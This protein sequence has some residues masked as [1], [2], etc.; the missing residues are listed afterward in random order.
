M[1]TGQEKSQ[2][3]N[4]SKSLKPV[5]PGWGKL[6]D[7][8]HLRYFSQ[9]GFVILMAVIFYVR[10]LYG[11]GPQASA[12]EAFCPLGGFETL[13]YSLVNGGKF[14]EHS[15]LSNMVLFIA[16]LLTAVAAGGFF[17]GWVC[18]LGTIQQAVTGSRRWLQRQ[19]PPLARFGGWLKAKTRPLTFLDKWLGYAKYGVLA[20]IIWGTISAGVMVFRNVDPWAGIINI[21]ESGITVG[22]WVF[23][24][25]VVAAVIGD[26]VWCRYLCP[27][28]AIIGLVSRIGL[29]RVQRDGLSCIGCKRCSTRCP[30]HIQVHKESRV[31]S[32]SCNMCLNCVD[33]CPSQGALETRLMLPISQKPNAIEMESAGNER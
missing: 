28:G 21:A 4:K 1:N 17:C 2:M 10:N 7:I 27:L 26:R 24:G 32:T 14:I 12:P 25:T 20:W 8:Q 13:Y 31:T 9:L 18:P 19:V 11:E 33:V 22:F 5:A 29:I 6:W 16:I 3:V 30:M 23:V 15:H